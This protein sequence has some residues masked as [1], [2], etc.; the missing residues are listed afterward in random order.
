MDEAA[1]RG[2]VNEAMQA[3]VAQLAATAAAAQT[4]SPAGTPATPSDQAARVERPFSFRP[5]DIGYFD[6][7]SSAMPI[8]VKERILLCYGR[9][10]MH[11]C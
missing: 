2:I 8:E 7:N 10:L 11:A 9:I 6:P 4:N 1:V 5:R 3:A